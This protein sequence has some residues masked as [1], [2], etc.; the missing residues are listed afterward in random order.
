M[1]YYIRITGQ[2]KQNKKVTKNIITHIHTHCSSPC[3]QNINDNQIPI[4]HSNKFITL[5]LELTPIYL[6]KW[7][8]G[9][10][11]FDSG[12]LFVQIIGLLICVDA[13]Y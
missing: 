3:S 1:L 9:L 10:E 4:P 12:G 2:N 7:G 11:Y 13:V 5:F 6:L 8:V